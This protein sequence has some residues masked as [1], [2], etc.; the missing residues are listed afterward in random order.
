MEVSAEWDRHKE[1]TMEFTVVLIETDEGETVPLAVSGR[2]HEAKA[3]VQEYVGLLFPQGQ[4]PSLE[5]RP[6]GDTTE[7]SRAKHYTAKSPH[8]GKFHCHIVETADRVRLGWEMQ[9]R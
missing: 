2:I 5:W 3:F 1:E 8:G 4:A 9:F 6:T 7:H